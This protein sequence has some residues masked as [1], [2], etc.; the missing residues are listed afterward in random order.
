MKTVTERDPSQLGLFDGLIVDNFAGAGGASVGIELAMGRPVSIA[1]NHDEAAV[2]LHKENHPWTRHFREDVFA[3]D[4]RKE[5]GGRRVRLAW[6][7]PDCKHFSRAKGAALVDRKIRGLAWVVLRWA[8]TVHPDVILLENVPEF[9]TWGPV[10]KGKPVKSKAGQTYRKWYAQLTTLGYRIETREICA[11]DLGVPTIRTRFY[12]IARRDGQPIRWPE[13]THGKRTSEAVRSGRLLPW[14][15]AAECID[16]LL[17]CFSIF[18]S[19]EEIRKKYG[20]K[21]VRPLAENTMARAAHGL[22][23]FVIR[24]AEPFI[25]DCNHSGG[26]HMQGV[27]EPLRTITSHDTGGLVSPCLLQYHT[28]QGERVRGQAV[29]DPLMTVDGSNR[30]GLM[31]AYLSEYYGNAQDGITLLDPMHTATGRDREGLTVA[32]IHQF[33][34]G[35][36][37]SSVSG[38]LPTVTSWDHNS[39][40]LAHLAHF[41][42]SGQRADVCGQDMREPLRTVTAADGQFAEVRTVVIRAG[43]GVSLGHWPEVRAM[44]N[45][46]CGYALGEEE[47]LLL[48]IRNGWYFIYDVGLRMLTPR[49]LARAMGFP[50]D[51]VIER[52][53]DGRE[54]PR[55]QQ[56]AKIGN[57]VCPRVAEALVRANLPECAPS[58]FEGI[59]ELNRYMSV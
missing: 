19:K 54:V 13:Q 21:V 14:R 2:M 32:H 18:E 16:W 31:A 29:E 11:A 4:P 48:R 46:Y 7:S 55:S 20:A 44:L 36:D 27:S 37:G 40:E 26:G 23:K 38:P 59:G 17:P 49:E 12:L 51:Y 35:V 41:K 1:V 52:F 58:R 5:C 33:F 57:A 42:G 9:V 53:A 43:Q 34:G 24:A 22:D 50:D 47:V 10:R 15:S 30:Y 56:V 6:F 39:L 25:V 45:Q 28:E 8:G 3:I